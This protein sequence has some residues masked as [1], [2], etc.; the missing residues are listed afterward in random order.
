MQTKPNPQRVMQPIE[1]VEGPMGIN[2]PKGTTQVGSMKTEYFPDPEYTWTYRYPDTITS[3]GI[4]DFYHK[5]LLIHGWRIRNLSSSMIGK[6]SIGIQQWTKG[7][8]KIAL[9]IYPMTDDSTFQITRWK[10]TYDQ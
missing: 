2:L 6:Y 5:D 10:T 4:W 9:S 1:V 7:Q 3:R 8:Q